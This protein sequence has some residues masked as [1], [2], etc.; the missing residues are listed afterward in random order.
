MKKNQSSRRLKNL[1]SRKQPKKIIKASKAEEK[2]NEAKEVAK[3]KADKEQAIKKVSKG[4]KIIAE[5]EGKG[6]AF[7][8]V[9]YHVRNNWGKYGLTR[10]MINS[11]GFFFFQFKALQSLEDVLENGPC[12]IRNSPI[13]IKKWSM[14][15][16]LCKEELICIS[17]WVKI[18]DVLIQGLGF[19]IETVNIE[20][21]W[22]PP[23]CD[24]CKIFGHVQDHYPKKVSI[25]PIVDTPIV[26]Q[27]VKYKPKATPNVPKKGATII[28][29]ASKSSLSQ[30]STLLKNQPF[31]A[32]VPPTKEGNIT[33]S[34]SYA[35]LD[36]ESEEEMENVYDESANILNSTKTVGVLSTFTVA[37][38]DTYNS[39][40]E[41][42]YKI[43]EKEAD[44]AGNEDLN[45]ESE[46]EN[47]EDEICIATESENQEKIT[48][49][50]EKHMGSEVEDVFYE[51]SESENEGLL[52]A[53]AKKPAKMKNKTKSLHFKSKQIEKE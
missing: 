8:V 4:K 33:M 39:V 14:I 46:K 26:K 3:A 9:E 40:L 21:E 38:E 36:D 13:I 52:V 25:P 43:T 23:R 34:N 28:G 7:S 5:T 51:G 45:E 11:K 53:K 30:V 18:H 49:E 20:Y 15:T 27:N 22:K 12:M 2:K 47:D 24:L 6:I 50:E 1:L 48:A 31:K 41:H 42:I 16:R 37:A 32:N 19:T 35:A 10:I 44:K 17:M 29:T